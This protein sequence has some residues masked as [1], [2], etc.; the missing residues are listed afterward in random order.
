MF[1]QIN[2]LIVYSLAYVWLLLII[3][4]SSHSA[5]Q[6]HQDLWILPCEH[7]WN[8]PRQTLA[9]PDLVQAITISQEPF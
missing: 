6:P 9:A 4:N 8:P 5:P 1:V 3:L 2:D 7:L